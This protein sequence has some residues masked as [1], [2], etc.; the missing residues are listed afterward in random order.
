VIRSKGRK[1]LL[2]FPLT[3]LQ[4]ARTCECRM[5]QRI[6]GR[7][8]GIFRAFSLLFLRLLLLVTFTLISRCGKQGDLVYVKMIMTICVSCFIF[9]L[10]DLSFLRFI[11]IWFHVLDVSGLRF[12]LSLC[13]YSN[14]EVVRRQW[15]YQYV[16]LAEGSSASCN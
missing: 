7:F 16:D 8:V 11:K 2:S 14:L 9:V 15:A 12:R 6:S 4:P 5:C 3:I 10:S 13:L 1:L